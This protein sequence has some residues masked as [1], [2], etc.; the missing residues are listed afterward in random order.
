M[1]RVFVG[2]PTYNRPHLVC[3]TIESLRAQRFQD[4]QALVSDNV[5]IAAAAD[6]V[7]RFVESLGDERIRFHR[8]AANEGEYGQGRL[9]LERSRGHEFL[10]ILHDDDLIAPDYLACAVAALDAA[11]EVDVFAA[12]FS[13]IG[14]DGGRLEAATAERRRLLGREGAAAGRYDIR[15]THVMSGFTPISGTMF[16]RRVFEASGFADPDKVGNY[17]FECDLFLRLG[18]VRAQGW[19]DPGER[20]ALREHAE[21]LKS[22]LAMQDNPLV[23]EPMLAMF[24]Q[25]RFEG[26]VERRR[27]VLVSHFARADGLIRLR[28]GDVAGARRQ[29]RRALAENPLSPKAWMLAAAVVLAPERLRRRLPPLQVLRD[30]TQRPAPQAGTPMT[31]G[32]EAERR[33]A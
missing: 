22:A 18:D 31:N 15:D 14:L 7:A 16:R 21:S 28:R 8:Q 5:S 27:R 17:P 11:P 20:L 2:I 13:M 19:F 12:N 23:V 30:V 25:R 26:P 1:A 6:E 33:P 3:E 9:F 32:P 10:V 4:W 29:L 24:G